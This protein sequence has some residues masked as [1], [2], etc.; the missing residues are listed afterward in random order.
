MKLG[1]VMF[2]VGFYCLLFL[3]AVDCDLGICGYEMML[4]IV[5]FNFNV[6]IMQILV[7]VVC[8]IFRFV[9]A[10]AAAYVTNSLLFVIT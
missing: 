6:G 2:D 1:L 3:I 7:Q 9:W 8:F 5:W 10:F 4:Y